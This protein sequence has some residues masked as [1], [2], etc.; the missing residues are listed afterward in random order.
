M[1]DSSRRRFLAQ[2]VIAAGGVAC[3]CAA[4]RHA[5][6]AGSPSA[7]TGTQEEKL[8]PGYLKLERDG[9]LRKIED[10]LWLYFR[11]CRCCPRAC[12]ADRLKGER[13]T[14]SS[15]ARLK[16]YSAGPHHGEERSLSGSRGSGTVFFS[17]CNLLCCYCQNWQINHR[18]DGDF[19]THSD[20][21]GIMLDLQRRGCHNINLVTPTHV[22]P[23]IVKA[24]RLAIPRGL[25]LPLVYNTGGYD[26]VEIIRLLEGV[27]DIYLPDFKYTDGAKAAK[28]SSGASDYP[29]VAAAVIKEM[30]RQVGELH[31]D[32]NRIAH[33]GL[34]VRHLVLPHN[35]AGTDRFAR[36]IAQELSPRTCVNLMDQYRPEHRA[37]D[38]PELSRR[39]TTIEWQQA[40]AWAREAGLTNLC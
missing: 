38:Y 1:G 33:R 16:V 5:D 22:V 9:V 17:N 32:E 30:N 11:S 40:L 15:T 3:S 6:D 21:A 28:Y 27:V 29:E 7:T 34:I 25:R 36:W 26:N 31:V 18:G 4:C 37:R 14:C 2:S 23:H 20:L 8:E 12:G 35:I 19:I 39:L 13:G 24:L 10:E